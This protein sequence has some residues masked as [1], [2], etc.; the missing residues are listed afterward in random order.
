MDVSIVEIEEPKL[1]EGEYEYLK[2]LI[3]IKKLENLV[4]KE[5]FGGINFKDLNK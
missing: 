1:L 2:A 3:E 4:Q 5:E